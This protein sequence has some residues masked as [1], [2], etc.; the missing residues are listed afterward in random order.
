[1]KNVLLAAVLAKYRKFAL[2]YMNKKEK[3]NPH[4]YLKLWT[5]DKPP[6][7]FDCSK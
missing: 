1:M 4:V 7:L 5:N 2:K 3:V 6:F